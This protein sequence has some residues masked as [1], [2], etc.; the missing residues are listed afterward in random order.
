MNVLQLLIMIVLVSVAMNA[1]A[2]KSGGK[3]GGGGKP[4]K[5]STEWSDRP[6]SNHKAAIELYHQRK[7]QVA[8]SSML[9]RLGEPSS[10]DGS[11]NAECGVQ[12]GRRC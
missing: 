4:P 9:E 10:T 5:T 11:L 8:R 1:S 3:G 6:I 12:K 7:R 2:A